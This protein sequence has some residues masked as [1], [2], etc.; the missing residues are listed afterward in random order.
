M[1]STNPPNKSYINMGIICYIFLGIGVSPKARMWTSK[2]TAIVEHRFSDDISS[3]HTPNLG[4]CNHVVA[5]R[6]G[7]QV[8]DKVRNLIKHFSPDCKNYF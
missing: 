5:N 6:T 3:G 1:F 8:Q 2:D 4:V 7:K